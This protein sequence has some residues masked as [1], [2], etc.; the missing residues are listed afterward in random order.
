MLPLIS[1]IHPTARI[2]AIG[3]F[4][5][6]WRDA[7]RQCMESCADPSRV[8]YVITVHKSRWAAFWEDAGV[9][10]AEWEPIGRLE[11]ED[12][13]CF[14]SC[15]VLRNDDRDC[16]VDQLNCAARYTTG[17][18][19]LGIMDDLECPQDWDDKLRALMAHV[20]GFGGAWHIDLTGEGQPWMVYGAVTRRRYEHQGYILHPEFES[21][22]ADN[23]V[24][25]MAHADGVVI[26]GRDL[27]FKHRHFSRGETEVDA[28]YETQNDPAKYFH[29]RRTWDKLMGRPVQKAVAVCLP[30]EQYQAGW[31]SSWTQLFGHLVGQRGFMT[32]PFFGHTSNVYC[33][34]IELAKGVLE[35]GVKAD[36]VLW[37]DDDNTLLPAQFDRLL[38]DLEEHPELDGVVGWCW[39]DNHQEKADQYS[40]WTM[41]C[42]KQGP[43]ME[44]YRFTPEDI[45]GLGP[46]VSSRDI[47]AEEG[48][49]FWSGFPC[50]LMRREV[51]ELLTPGAF[52]PV[53]REDINYKFSG[54]DTAFFWRARHA[55]LN[56]AVDLRVKVP[57]VKWR[58]IEPV[59]S[60]APAAVDSNLVGVNA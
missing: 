47:E 44:C 23:H 6:G 14:G 48:M 10:R 20:G 38:A 27:G 52:A 29:G 18:L 46:L 12:V 36:Y 22:F 56:F 31:V 2:G 42:G 55:G 8:E 26:D 49:G 39:C 5:R 60:T 7:A 11:I 19:I 25:E 16:V 35:V 43:N 41:S 57:H 1:C 32:L 37:M 9:K 15:V 59:F 50:V 30:G 17:D 58:I 51:L 33:T 40:T 13:E 24:S 45:K 4:P 54:E 3:S 21:M 28:V 53:F 34:R